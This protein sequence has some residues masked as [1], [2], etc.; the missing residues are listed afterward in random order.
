MN[1]ALALLFSPV[2]VPSGEGVPVEQKVE[3]LAQEAAASA[4]TKLDLFGYA[5]VRGEME[6]VGLDQGCKPADRAVREALTRHVDEIV[7]EARSAVLAAIP[8]ERL[9]AM[10][11]VSLSAGF[12]GQYRSRVMALM[13]SRAQK[14]ISEVDGR[15]V[16]Q[17]LAS[18]RD[19]PDHHASAGDEPSLPGVIEAALGADSAET[20]QRAPLLSMACLMRSPPPGNFRIESD[21]K[22]WPE[23]ERTQ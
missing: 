12:G 19:L 18:L 5:A 17:V 10:N 16:A 20:F 9:R 22:V 3:I 2:I 14:E 13:K 21:G 6:R 7:P 4:Y 1:P 23:P 8:R 15:A 11:P